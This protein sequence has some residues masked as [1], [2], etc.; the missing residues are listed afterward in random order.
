MDRASSPPVVG[1]TPSL[2]GREPVVVGAAEGPSDFFD[3]FTTAAAVVKTGCL[4][5]G[6]QSVIVS[7]SAARPRLPAG[8]W[9]SGSSQ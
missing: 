2:S 3:R 7:S 9:P 5:A 8:S 6:S 1:G 4:L